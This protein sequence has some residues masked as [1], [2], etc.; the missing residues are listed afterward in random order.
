MNA[1]PATHPS[2][3]TLALFIDGGLSAASRTDVM[4]HV[5]SCAECRDVVLTTREIRAAK[6]SLAPVVRGRFDSIRWMPA[7]AVMAAAALLVILFLSPVRERFLPPRGVEKLVRA[8][9]PLEYRRVDARLTGGFAYR[10]LAPVYRGEP[11]ADPASLR[12]LQAAGEIQNAAPRDAESLHAL[13]LSHLLL[14]RADGAVKS[15]TAALGRAGDDS[16]LRNEI[17]T[18][19]AAAH[20]ARGTDASTAYDLAEKAWNATRSPESAWNRA[21][22]AE[23]LGRND[24]ARQ[25]W[26]DYLRVDPESKWAGEAKIRRARL[27]RQGG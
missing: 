17:L 26:D 23:L 22:A 12:L 10:P 5:A 14:G 24:V 2:D 4:A 6:P 1:A 8:T 7:A 27:A 16:D 25:A 3:E 21:V 13:G 19:L 18:D 15:L 20:I 11:A 9:E